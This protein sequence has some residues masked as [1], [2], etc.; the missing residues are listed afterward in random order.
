M[1]SC[2]SFLGGSDNN[3]ENLIRDIL[4]SMKIHQINIHQFNEHLVIYLKK[5]DDHND[6]QT[7]KAKD[8]EHFFNKEFVEC[9]DNNEFYIFQKQIMMDANSKVF[10]YMLMVTAFSLAK[11]SDDKH[12]YIEK[13][14]ASNSESVNYRSFVHFLSFYLNLNIREFTIKIANEI[15]KSHG[16]IRNYEINSEMKRDVNDLLHHGY[17][18]IDV[19]EFNKAMIDSLDSVMSNMKLRED[20]FSMDVVRHFEAKNPFIFDC[21][22]LREHYYRHYLHNDR[23]RTQDKTLNKGFEGERNNSMK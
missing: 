8:L 2:C 14:L 16:L 17:D 19:E 4:S 5:K 12:N 21:I 3:A 1:G 22:R 15:L 6:N 13:I 7:L 11:Y 9:H 10:N 18:F 23:D 20:E